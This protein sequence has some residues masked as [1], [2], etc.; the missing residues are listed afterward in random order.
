MTLYRFGWL[1]TFLLSLQIVSLA[2]DACPYPKPESLTCEKDKCKQ[3]LVLSVCSGPTSDRK[4]DT[5]GGPP[6]SCCGDAAPNAKQASEACTG[7]APQFLSELHRAEKSTSTEILV[8][9]CGGKFVRVR[10]AEASK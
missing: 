5:E 8:A 1:V 7:P 3:T 4:C 2:Q 9:S 6:R 10:R